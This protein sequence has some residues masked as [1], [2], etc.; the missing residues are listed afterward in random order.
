MAKVKLPDMMSDYEGERIYVR[1]RVR[2]D[3]RYKSDY[4]NFHFLM[5]IKLLKYF[6]GSAKYESALF[7]T[8]NYGPV[9]TSYLN[10]F[11]TL[12]IISKKTHLI[13]NFLF[14]LYYSWFIY[15]RSV[16]SSKNSF[17]LLIIS[18]TS[19]NRASRVSCG[20]IGFTQNWRAHIHFLEITDFIWK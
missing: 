17:V 18:L 13:D 1:V 14:L 15:Q 2:P 11:C 12:L 6:K 5:R 19:Q 8:K 20:T 16:P 9:L 4:D 7:S 3:K 10:C